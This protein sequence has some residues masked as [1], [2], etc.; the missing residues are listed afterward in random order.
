MKIPGSDY[1][2]GKFYQRFKEDITLIL[3]VSPRK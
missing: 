3:Q 2:T 1:F